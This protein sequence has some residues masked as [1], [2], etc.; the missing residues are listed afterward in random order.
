MSEVHP[1][2]PEGQPLYYASLCGF[3]GLVEHIIVTHSSDINSRG[4]LHVTP[5]HAASIK[6]HSDVAS[7]LPENGADLN[8][9]DDNGRV[10]LHKAS[11]GGRVVTVQSSMEVA[12][13]LIISSADVNVTDNKGWTPLHVAARNGHREIARL[14]L[15]SGASID[16][17]KELIPTPLFLACA[18]GQLEFSRFLVIRT[19]LPIQG[20]VHSTMHRIVWWAC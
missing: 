11:Q 3:R 10:P 8:Y 1:T 6:G 17:Q 14:L 20:S 13:L 9:C 2:R 5:L 16:A 4:G 15:E 19:E 7:L 12:Q 18:H